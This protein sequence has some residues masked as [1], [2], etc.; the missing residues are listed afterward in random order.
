MLHIAPLKVSQKSLWINCKLLISSLFMR[1]MPPLNNIFFPPARFANE[2]N[3]AQSLFLIP[4]SCSP[5]DV[6]H[7]HLRRKTFFF[8]SLGDTS[9]LVSRYADISSVSPLSCFMIS[10]LYRVKGVRKEKGGKKT[11]KQK[12]T[13]ERNT[14]CIFIHRLSS[15]IPGCLIHTLAT[16]HLAAPGSLIF[17]P[18]Y[19]VPSLSARR[20][21][22]RLAY[23]FFTCDCKSVK[24]ILNQSN[25]L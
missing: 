22:L 10:V 11:K 7:S 25:P 15:F 20:S 1:E 14:T 18:F 24:V 23:S 17:S 16:C 12:T 9:P 21:S 4:A 13:P 5:S 3:T 8:V 6:H 2:P 19:V